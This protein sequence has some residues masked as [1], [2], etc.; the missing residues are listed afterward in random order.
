MWWGAWKARRTAAKNYRNLLAATAQGK[1][2][3]IRV[4]RRLDELAREAKLPD[5]TRSQLLADSANEML[6]RLLGD[7]LPKAR[8]SEILE[9][10]DCIGVTDDFIRGHADAF[11]D[12]V[13]RIAVARANAGQLEV[14]RDPGII[15]NNG[16]A[17]YLQ[18]HASLMK[19]VRHATRGYGGLSFRLAKGVYYHIGSSRGGSVGTSLEEADRGTLTVT[20]R[21]VVYTGQRQ[22]REMLHSKIMA[23]NTYED[24]I[25]FNLSN[26]QN[27]PLFRLRK[28]FGHVVAA[29]LNAAMHH[30]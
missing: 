21:R 8:E 24:G 13:I 3:S 1:T 18:V 29:T 7:S 6:D 30:E 17:A 4:R 10:I 20:S 16:E 12:L 22:S 14:L 28:G 2:D 25:E 19:Q 5:P 11:P 23:V 27:A 15:L 9:R 26:R